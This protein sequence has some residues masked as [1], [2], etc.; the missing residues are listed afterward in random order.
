MRTFRLFLALALLCVAAASVHA[1]NK[2]KGVLNLFCWSE[3][4]PQEVID[5][6]TKQTGITVNVE[7]YASN[8][9]MLSK[10]LESEGKYDLIQPSE[11][12]IEALIKA[13]KLEPL[14]L[15]AIPNI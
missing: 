7:N 9:E 6:F 14:H 4:V 3:Y 15:E 12:T 10:L 11:Y 1:E 8:E 13:N 2:K 5:G